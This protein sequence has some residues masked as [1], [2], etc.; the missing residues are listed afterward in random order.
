MPEEKGS[1]V[2]ALDWK[3]SEADIVELIQGIDRRY[4]VELV[5]HDK[6]LQR[7][8]FAG[9]RPAHLPWK[10]VPI[11]LARYANSDPSKLQTLVTAWMVSNREILRE[12]SALSAVDLREGVIEMLVRHGIENRS[13][14]LWALRLDNRPEVQKA[15][16]QGLAQELSGETR[17]L[18]SQAQGTLLAEALENARKQLAEA[19]AKTHSI[20]AELDKLRRLIQHKTQQLETRRISHETVI[21]ELQQLRTR[22]GRLENQHQADQD[23]IAE[24]QR[25]LEDERAVSQELRRSMSDLKTTLRAQAKERGTDE[26]LLK[27]EEERKT[28]A[29]LRL[30]VTRL[31][32]RLENAYTK[33]D[34]AWGQVE[35]LRKELKRVQY[36]KEVIIEEKRRL[37]AQVEELQAELKELR[38]QHDEQAYE[39]VLAAIPIADLE[40]AWLNARQAIRE[41]IHSVLSTMRTASKTQVKVNKVDLWQEWVEREFSLVKDALVALDTY[42]ETKLLPD[43]AQLQEAQKLL[44]LRWY[45][46]EYTRQAIRCADEETTFPV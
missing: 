12:V 39:Q 40:S 8:V 44:A 27:L 14:I 25:Q 21:A 2:Q 7:R 15:L 4:I 38:T 3:L 18:I 10:Q 19:E 16:E 32:Q 24:L 11:K 6:Y 9:F 41:Y 17:T 20:Q 36:D 33:R 35:S 43:Q 34:E 23:T 13:Q 46:L 28:T 42:P 29:R 45:L 37:Q 30:K 31:E 5:K 26:A 22:T 1:P